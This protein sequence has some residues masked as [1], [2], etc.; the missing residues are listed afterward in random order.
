MTCL[1]QIVA[2]QIYL[3][4]GVVSPLGA[5]EGQTAADFLP[6]HAGKNIT[7][8]ILVRDLKIFAIGKY[9]FPAHL[10]FYMENRNWK[11]FAVDNGLY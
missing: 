2:D 6:W 10:K 11:P 3:G 9:Q 4:N 7:A 8:V 5:S 1:H